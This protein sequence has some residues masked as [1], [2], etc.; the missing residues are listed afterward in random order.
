MSGRAITSSHFR[1][2]APAAGLPDISPEAAKCVASYLV[3]IGEQNSDLDPLAFEFNRDEERHRE[4]FKTA[5]GSYGQEYDH[6]QD[7]GDVELV[8]QVFSACLNDE[9]R[10]RQS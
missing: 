10:Y 8:T 3:E 7:E 5:L 4:V 2:L 6:L 1:Q 9:A